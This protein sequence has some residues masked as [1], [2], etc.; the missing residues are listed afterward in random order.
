LPPCL[1]PF[2]VNIE[3]ADFCYFL[4]EYRSG[5]PKKAMSAYPVKNFSRVFNSGGNVIAIPFGKGVFLA[6][7]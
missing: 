2:D 5:S 3:V 1:K 6:I 7:I 4:A